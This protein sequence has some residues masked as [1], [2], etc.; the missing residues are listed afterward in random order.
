MGQ[1]YKDAAEMRFLANAIREA[2]ES[3]RDRTERKERMELAEELGR[4]ADTR[5]LRELEFWRP[6]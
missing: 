2:A 3:L 4:L 1:A 6:D 5:E